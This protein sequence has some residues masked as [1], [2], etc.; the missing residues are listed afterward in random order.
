MVQKSLD[1]I[2]GNLII[3]KI[4]NHV[5]ISFTE[6]KLDAKLEAMNISQGE[7]DAIIAVGGDGTLNEVVAG[8]IEGGNNTPIAL[9]PAGTVNDFANWMQISHKYDIFSAILKNNKKMKVDVG[10]ANDQYFINVAAGGLLTNVGYKAS[11]ES[12]TVLG[13]LAYYVEGVREIPKQ[14]FKS[15][16]VDVECEEFS[17][18]EDIFMFLITNTPTVGG[19]RRIAPKALINDGKLDVCIIKKSDIA[20]VFYMLLRTVKGE[21]IFHPKV[22]YMQTSKITIKAVNNEIVDLDIDGEQ[23]SILPVTIETLPEAVEIYIP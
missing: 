22:Q 14:L 11:V 19:F 6:K 4:V 16:T 13:K 10:K 2:I 12:K 15:I 3:D 20:E 18:R 23:G 9:L 7:Y 1:K 5:D 8:V 17:G 21:H